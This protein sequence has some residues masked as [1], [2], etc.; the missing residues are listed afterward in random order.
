M[1]ALLPWK[2]LS[3]PIVAIIA[4]T[5]YVDDLFVQIG[6]PEYMFVR[7]FPVLLP[8]GFMVIF[9]PT[10]YWAP[11]RIVWRAIP[12]LNEWWFP[13]VNGIWVETTSSSRP[14]TEM[15]VAAAQSTK[16][17]TE[18]DPFGIPIQGD[19]TFVQIIN[20][21]F[22]VRIKAIRCPANDGFRS[23][24]VMPWRDPNIK[25]VNISFVYKQTVGGE[26]GVA[27]L[28]LD[29]DDFSK[30]EWTYSPWQAACT[31]SNKAATLS[32]EWKKTRKSL[33]EHVAEYCR[34]R[35]P[36]GNGNPPPKPPPKPPRKP[37][38]P[39]AARLRELRSWAS[40]VVRRRKT[41]G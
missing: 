30:A 21:F 35:P 2:W 9:G 36:G 38:N 5:I 26:R 18:K 40:N 3:I 8:V 33:N 22:T 25:T 23:I 7:Y 11:W 15:P 14:T 1:Y 12:R 10:G 13:D 17:I 31:G 6:V 16:Q 39:I 19:A 28:E 27:E 20:S 37:R 29:E 24:T 32:L 41:R 4:A 34:T